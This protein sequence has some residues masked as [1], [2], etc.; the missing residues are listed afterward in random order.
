[1]SSVVRCSD[2]LF[3]AIDSFLSAGVFAASKASDVIVFAIAMLLILLAT[4]IGLIMG[5]YEKATRY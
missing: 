1:M 2:R 4:L 5:I 3:R